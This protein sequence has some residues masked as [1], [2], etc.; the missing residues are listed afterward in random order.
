MGSRKKDAAAEL[1][2]ERLDALERMRE[3]DTAA[4]TAREAYKTA[5]VAWREHLRDVRNAAGTAA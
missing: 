4:A 3:T 2:A 5:D 1:H